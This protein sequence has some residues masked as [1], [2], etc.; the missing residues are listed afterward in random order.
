VTLA[1]GE[2]TRWRT[3]EHITALAA[4]AAATQRVRL[5]S[6]TVNVP[7]HPTAFLAK[8][9]A[10]IDIL[11]G[12]RYTMTAAIGG[13]P[14]DWLGSCGLRMR[15]WMPG[16]RSCAGSGMGRHKLTAANQPLPLPVQRDG[17]PILCSSQGPQRARP[18]RPLG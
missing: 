6:Y 14:Q 15:D 8:R 9:I 2:R 3:L 10:S 18:R 1:H 12:G 11:S 7:M 16:S 17:P 5:W 4:M 13:R